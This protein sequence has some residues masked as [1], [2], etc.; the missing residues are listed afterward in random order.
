[1]RP[2]VWDVREYHD[3][4][5][6]I[7]VFDNAATGTYAYVHVDDIVMTRPEPEEKAAD[8]I[9]KPAMPLPLAQPVAT[10]SGSKRIPSPRKPLSLSPFP[11]ELGPPPP[12]APYTTEMLPTETV[13]VPMIFPLL[14]GVPIHNNYNDDRG[15]HRH[16]GI[17]MQA[18]K[19]WPIVAPFSGTLGF[20]VYTF[21]IYGDNGYKCLGTHLNDDTPGT[22]DNTA[23]RD[24]MF[25]PN[26]RPGDHVIAGQFIG[27]VGNSGD[28][29]GPHLH[30][31]LFTPDGIRSPL[32]SLTAAQ[33]IKT[34][35]LNLSPMPP[36]PN[37]G[38]VCIIGCPRDY[39]PTRRVLTVQLV[40]RQKS[41]GSMVPCTTPKRYYLVLT[42]EQ[43]VAA[44]GIEGI[45]ALPRDRTIIFYGTETKPGLSTTVRQMLLSP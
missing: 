8:R 33:R 10:T 29:T 35:R 14:G 43:L 19:M 2:V 16:T 31:E 4:V 5:A 7:E 41:P 28:A 23:Q 45:N 13:V 17:D 15:P 20:K 36:A 38:E 3:K 27:Y 11:M 12:I 34:P 32:P 18:H 40:A 21:W 6:Q 26:I 37:A 30:F 39:E 42:P 44:G 1:M 22:N 25:A 24:F 9:E